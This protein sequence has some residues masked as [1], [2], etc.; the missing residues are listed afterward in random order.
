MSDGLG[1][2]KGLAQG[3]GEE[4]EQQN[5]QLDRIN[6]KVQQADMLLDNQNKQMYKI[7][8]KK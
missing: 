1:R 7:L 5:A 6:P 3:L 2:L 4:I 8:G